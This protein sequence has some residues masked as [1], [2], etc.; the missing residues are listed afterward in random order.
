MPV[1]ETQWGGNLE[2][3]K[4]FRQEV[5]K[6]GLPKNELDVFDALIGYEELD[7][8]SDN[9]AHSAMLRAAKYDDLDREINQIQTDYENG[10]W[11]DTELTVLFLPFEDTARRWRQI[12]MNGWKN[13]PIP[14]RLIRRVQ[15]IFLIWD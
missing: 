10:K 5:E 6:A 8:E 4:Q 3:M 13:T 12:T 2:E 11:T 9:K 1:L 7:G 14:M 15:T